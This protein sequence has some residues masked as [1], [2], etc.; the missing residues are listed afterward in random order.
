M[1]AMERKEELDEQYSNLT[2]TCYKS[3]LNSDYS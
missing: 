3:L 2:Q 1:Q